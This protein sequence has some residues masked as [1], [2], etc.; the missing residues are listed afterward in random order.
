MTGTFTLSDGN[1]IQAFLWQDLLEGETYRKYIEIRKK[2]KDGKWSSKESKLPVRKDKETGG[3]FFNYNGEKLYCNNFNF[4]TVDQLIEK[5]NEGLESNDRWHVRDDE[6]LATFLKDTEN[7]GFVTKLPVYDVI[8]PCM[9]LGLTSDKKVD[10]M[11]VPRV[12]G[13]YPKNNW[14]YKITLEAENKELHES[15]ASETYYMCDLCSSIKSGYVKVVN[16]NAYQSEFDIKIRRRSYC[17]N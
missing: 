16:R 5:V 1:I 7:L 6:I 15:V 13:R 3:V 10:V 8:I 4:M 14:G 2:N 12:D 9:G 17:E 11:C